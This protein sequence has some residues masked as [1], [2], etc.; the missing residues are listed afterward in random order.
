MM[1]PAN[2]MP[3]RNQRPSAEAACSAVRFQVHEVWEGEAK[4][5]ARSRSMA[6]FWDQVAERAVS[7]VVMFP[8]FSFCFGSTGV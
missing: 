6:G 7:D 5:D 8:H 1:N 2:L 3:G 4:V